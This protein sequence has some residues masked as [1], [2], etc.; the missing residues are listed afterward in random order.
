M[1]NYNKSQK[2]NHNY[3][4][5]HKLWLCPYTVFILEFTFFLYSCVCV[6]VLEREREGG[7]VL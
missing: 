2:G 7:V 1:K 3:I 4:K 5:I 6:C